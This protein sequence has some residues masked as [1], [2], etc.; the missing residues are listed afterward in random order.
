MYIIRIIDSKILTLNIDFF[1][2]SE[3]GHNF[4]I[5]LQDIKTILDNAK[6][7]A[8]FFSI[9]SNLR[10]ADLPIEKRDILLNTFKKLPQVILWKFEDENLPGKSDNIFIKNWFP[11]NDVLGKY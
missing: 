3:F 9:G 6:D 4:L 7:G 1:N 10:S 11:Q 8:I 2:Q 5:F